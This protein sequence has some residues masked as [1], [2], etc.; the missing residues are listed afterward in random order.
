MKASNQYLFRSDFIFN[1]CFGVV[2]LGDLVGRLLDSQTVDFIFKPLLLPILFIYF[3]VSVSGK[4]DL[5]FKL[6]L[7]ALFFSWL[8]D[9]FL[10]FEAYFAQGLL[11]FLIAHLCYIVAY[12]VSVKGSNKKSILSKYPLL[13]LPFIGYFLFFYGILFSKLGNLQIPVFVYALILIGMGIFA[14][15]RKNKVSEQSFLYIFIGAL[16]FI[17]SD[18]CIAINKFLYAGNLPLAGLIVMFTYIL[19]QYLIVKGSILHFKNASSPTFN[20]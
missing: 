20:S 8:G 16:F 7:F 19:A 2:A 1:C 9:I 17:L 6:I 10:L 12:Q 15:N 3:Y 4:K 13:L 14:L 5:F 18:S 11:S